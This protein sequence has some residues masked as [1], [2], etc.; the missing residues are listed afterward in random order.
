MEAEAETM[1]ERVTTFRSLPYPTQGWQGP[2]LDTAHHSRTENSLG[3]SKRF[4]ARVLASYAAWV[5]MTFLP[6]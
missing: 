2:G 5:F 6:Q 1:G 4:L 3:F